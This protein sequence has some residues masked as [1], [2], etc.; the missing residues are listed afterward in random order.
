MAR[1]GYSRVSTLE[2]NLARQDELLKNCERVFADKASGKNTD[3]PQ[4]KAMLD[5]VREGDVV[6]VE[7]YSRLSRSTADLLQIVGELQA[8]GVGFISLKE[9]VDTTTPAGT[10]VMTIFAGLAQFE[11]EQLLQRQREGINI[12]KAQGKYKGRQKIATDEA[13]FEAAYKRWR[14]GQQTARQTMEELN[15]KPNTF[16]RRVKEYEQRLS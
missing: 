14:D 10:L 3:R 9:Q 12:A 2:Q 13:A 7:S 16:Y 8:K 5:Y 15:L 6:V 4:L 11:R 1:I